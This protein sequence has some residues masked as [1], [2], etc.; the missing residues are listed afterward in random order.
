MKKLSMI[1]LSLFY[2][3]ILLI[4][5]GNGLAIGEP[6][7]NGDVFKVVDQEQPNEP[8]E[9][10]LSLEGIPVYW[11]D[12]AALVEDDG[13]VYLSFWRK[14]ADGVP[15]SPENWGGLPQVKYDQKAGEI[16]E[17]KLSLTLPEEIPDV[18]L[19]DSQYYT[20]EGIIGISTLPDYTGEGTPGLSAGT[21][22]FYNLEIR[23]TGRRPSF[24]YFSF[25]Y[26]NRDGRIRHPFSGYI[27]L[28]KGW[29]FLVFTDYTTGEY[30]R[31][32]SLQKIYD[33]YPFELQTYY[34]A[35][36]DKPPQ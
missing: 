8:E 20:A 22:G 26:A 18:F 6:G 4:S 35:F 7:Q 24:L 36:D 10:S 15:A 9:Y 33:S 2:I 12:S 34:Y 17:G 25:W 21:A 11:R 16:K 31:Y 23:T 27:D 32:R 19:L 14:D 29:N 30:V 28:K 1:F 5:C 13:P 3:G